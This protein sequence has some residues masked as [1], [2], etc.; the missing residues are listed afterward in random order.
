MSMEFEFALK[1]VKNAEF[2]LYSFHFSSKIQKVYKWL[3]TRL[4]LNNFDYASL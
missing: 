2:A 4:M 3:M 1:W